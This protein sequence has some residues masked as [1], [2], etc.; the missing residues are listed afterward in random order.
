VQGTARENTH[1]GEAS[2]TASPTISEVLAAYLADEK[3]RLAAKTY[4]PYA[5]VIE[6]LQHSLNGYAANSLDKGEYELWEEL[7]NADGDQHREFCEIFGPEHILPN[8][9]EFLSY[10]MVSKVMAGP[11]L[12]RASG[13]VTKKLAKW[14]G[15]KGYATAEQAEDAVERG[16]DAARDLPMAEKLLASLYEFTSNKYSPDD[17][18]IEDRFEIKRV[19]PG[20]V[21]LE[22]FDDD[23]LLGPIS[24]PPQATTLCRVGWT[25]SGAVR[26]T[27][28]KWVLIEA[29]KVYP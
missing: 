3:A 20:K 4:G 29:W 18:D 15:D 28:K 27:G 1:G 14:L 25:I 23:R 19:E 11:D 8:I 9:G 26:E 6:L 5:D 7:F 2:M 12:L 21:W 22:G 10:F 16:T 13:I 24:L 17:A